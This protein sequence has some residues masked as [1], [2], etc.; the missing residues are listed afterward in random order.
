MHQPPSP[1]PP[2]RTASTEQLPQRAPRTSFYMAVGCLSVIVGLLLGVGG[3]FGVRALQDDGGTSLGQE[4]RTG[5]D[6]G[7]E[8]EGPEVQALDESP[9]GPDAAVPSG[10]TFPLH[11]DALDSE[12][13]VSGITVDWDATTEILETNS[14]TEEPQEGNKY[15]LLSMEGVYQGEERHEANGRAW[16]QASYVA[17]DGT[18]HARTFL[19][20][21]NSDDLV[22]WQD[23]DAGGTFL[24]EHAFEIPEEIGGGGH[25]VLHESGQDLAEGIWIIA[26]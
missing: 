22:E 10:S 18:V 4:G 11:S 7:G 16:M 8:G 15:V 17:E 2:H 26:S 1:L 25:F 6:E 9:V 21:P 5:S 3:F 14:F 12:V 23:V 24:S 13:E 19:V 20:T